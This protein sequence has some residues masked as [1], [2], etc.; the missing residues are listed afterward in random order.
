MNASKKETLVL[1]IASVMGA[2]SIA[3]FLAYHNIA[4]GDLW[5]R[6]AQGSSVWYTGKLMAKDMFSF[7]PTFARYVDHEWGSGLIFFSL[8]KLFGPASLLFFKIAAALGTIYFALAAGR[9][10]KVSRTS[11]LA[12]GIFSTWAI[13]PG[14][15]PVVRCHTITYLF[16][17][18]SLF[19]LELI[20]SGRRWPGAVLVAMCA[21]WANLHSGFALGLV[22]IAVYTLYAF[23]SKRKTLIMASILA[24]SILATLINPYG[25]E[26]W[27]Y[28][29]RVITHIPRNVSEWLPMPL[30]G[31]DSFLGFRVL[32]LLAV[33]VIAAGWERLKNKKECLPGLIILALTAYMTFR[34]RRHAPLFG[35]ACAAFLGTYVDSAFRL[36]DSAR[37]LMAL[38]ALYIL[39][40]FLAVTFILPRTP[41][42]VLSPVGFYPVR[43]VDIL[44]QSRSKGNLL[45]PLRWGNYAMWRL[46]PR[47]KVS[48]SGRY[49]TIYPESVRELN[50]DFFFR[51]GP[52]WDRILKEYEI[53]YIMLEMKNA[54]ITQEDLE[55]RG[56]DAVWMSE[57]SSLFA[58]KDMATSL[59]DTARSL[60]P[61]TIEPLDAKI[62]ENWYKID[63]KN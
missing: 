31:L 11:L 7:T 25:I 12:L 52:E 17:G 36:K 39:M 50:H 16:F 61:Y 14:F 18:I 62:P 27:K 49:D 5:S 41:F 15:I 6:L 45:V 59:K 44:T 57:C 1:T 53:D 24:A 33:I 35:I 63:A 47:I 20:R 23:L 19:L 38:G 21:L 3:I 37:S 29:L 32:F 54:K 42:M 2:V 43:E 4:D 28:L 9:L 56:Y 55:S 51:N 22:T 48:I 40:A 58:K 46:Y 34:S 10:L 13:F 8:L 26:L 60:P 30:T